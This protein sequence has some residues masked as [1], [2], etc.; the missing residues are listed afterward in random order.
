MGKTAG[1]KGRRAFNGR[2][3]VQAPAN[4]QGAERRR[5]PITSAFGPTHTR[6]TFLLRWTGTA[7]G[8]GTVR[9]LISRYE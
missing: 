3:K 9:P 5:E 8:A 7:V 1:P 2:E 4:R 6:G